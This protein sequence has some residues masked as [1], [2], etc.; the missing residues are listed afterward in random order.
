M[1]VNSII[2]SIIVFIIGGFIGG[3]MGNPN[4]GG[5]INSEIAKIILSGLKWGG[6]TFLLGILISV[7]SGI[8]AIIEKSNT[9]QKL[10]KEISF[11]KKQSQ[12][13]ISYFKEKSRHKLK[14]LLNLYG[15]KI[16]SLE[17]ENQRI[18][19]DRE[20]RS[21]ELQKDTKKEIEGLIK[22][23]NAILTDDDENF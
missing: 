22:R 1:L 5:S 2:I 17:L 14:L 10:L 7:F 4:L 3:T 8:S 13:E 6:V 18:I 11:V 21:D 15:E 12:K 19:E 20:K 23:L 16:S 9:R